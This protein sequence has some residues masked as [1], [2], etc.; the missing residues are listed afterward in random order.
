M[1]SLPTMTMNRD[2]VTT[3]KSNPI[4]CRADRVV[5][6]T[7]ELSRSLHEA[8]VSHAVTHAHLSKLA[9]DSAERDFSNMHI[10]PAI[11]I[12]K[13]PDDQ[14]EPFS[15]D[16]TKGRAVYGPNPLPH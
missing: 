2:S 7:N 15:P 14:P 6:C 12:S 11:L 13:P 16:E 1:D 5:L 9:S 4:M 3:R 10:P 8:A